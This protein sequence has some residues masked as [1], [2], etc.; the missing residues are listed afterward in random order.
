MF[1]FGARQMMKRCLIG[2]Y[3][4]KDTMK[5]QAPT[6]EMA[7]VRK[8]ADTI[9]KLSAEIKGKL[10]AGQEKL[11]QKLD[12]AVDSAAKMAKNLGGDFFGK[13][14]ETALDAGAAVLDKGTEL[15]A[16][17]TGLVFEKLLDGLAKTLD[18]AIAA[19]DEPFA[20]VGKDIFNAKKT[21][22][23]KCYC[24][25]IDGESC[26]IKEPQEAVRGAAPYGEAEYKACQ[27]DKCV[28]TMQKQC[29][30]EMQKQMGQVVLEEVKKH[31]V[32]STWDSLIK[33]YNSCID[34]LNKFV[35]KYEI[36]K[37]LSMEKFKLDIC[38]YIVNQTIIEFYVLMA[39]QE[40]EIRKN[41][42]QFAQKT[43]M[44]DLFPLLFSGTPAYDE[45]NITHYANM[46]RNTGVPP[47]A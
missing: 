38:T 15:A 11:D 29:T 32:T 28:R 25:I 10:E 33:A 43:D 2:A 46:K 1:D 35:D 5:V 17:G 27:P 21:E 47:D 19:I 7:A 9:H 36:L 30:E 16:S 39:N 8:M 24:D 20:T 45:F 4:Q 23:I 18:A 13:A 14:T 42:S 40:I 44:P 34:E 26:R 22:I 31:V 37:G 6:D 12:S 3:A 41:P